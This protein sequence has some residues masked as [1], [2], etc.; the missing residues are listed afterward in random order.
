MPSTSTLPI[1]TDGSQPSF[2]P[3]QRGLLRSTWLLRPSQSRHGCRYDDPEILARLDV[4]LETQSGEVGWSLFSLTYR[5]DGPIS[6]IFRKEFLIHYRKLF[7]FL[8]NAK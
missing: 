7:M 8:W 2:C 5:T 6:P 4:N 1:P 3:A